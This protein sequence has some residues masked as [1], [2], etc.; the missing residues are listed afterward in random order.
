M[1]PIVL[2]RRSMDHRGGFDAA[3]ESQ[4]YGNIDET[5]VIAHTASLSEHLGLGP[6]TNPWRAQKYGRMQVVPPETPPKTTG[7][8]MW[9]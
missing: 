9:H 8:E 6:Q 1:L 7:T 2:H 4:Q 3:D 5:S